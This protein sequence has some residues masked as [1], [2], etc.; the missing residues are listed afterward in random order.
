MKETSRMDNT[1]ERARTGSPM[2][3]S[4]MEDGNKDNIMVSFGWR[5]LC[6]SIQCRSQCFARSRNM[7]LE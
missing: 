4:T 7:Y 3:V 5:S 6:I 2:E 1:K